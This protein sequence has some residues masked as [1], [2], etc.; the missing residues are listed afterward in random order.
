MEATALLNHTSILLL[1]HD[2]SEAPSQFAAMLGFLTS[3]LAAYTA[4]PKGDVPVSIQVKCM[5]VDW[6]KLSFGDRTYTGHLLQDTFNELH[7]ELDD[8]DQHL[9]AIHPVG[10]LF[11]SGDDLE[12]FVGT[13]EGKCSASTLL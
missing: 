9:D 1:A 10:G 2:R 12:S 13:F 6:N 8:G 4:I 3:L 5:G 7:E 11:A